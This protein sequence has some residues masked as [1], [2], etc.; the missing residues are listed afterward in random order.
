MIFEQMPYQRP[1]LQ[2]VLKVYDELIEKLKTNPPV[3]EAEKIIDRHTQTYLPV[4][5]M[6]SLSAIRHSINTEDAFYTAEEEFYAQQGPVLGEKIA[7]MY[8]LLLK[9]DCLPQLKKIF[10]EVFF[11]NAEIETKTI[12]PAVLGELEEENMLV[13]E[14]Q[15][16]Q[17]GAQIRFDGKV[18][19]LSQLGVYKEN[20]DRAVRRAAYEAE[21]GFYRQ[22]QR[23]YDEIYDKLVKVRTKIAQKLGFENF[24]ELGYLRM[25]R[26]CYRAQQVKVF[27]KEV[28]TNIVPIVAEMKKRQAARIGVTDFKL[29]DDGVIRKGG[30]PAP[31]G[32]FDDTYRAGV[33]MYRAMTPLTKEFIDKMDSMHLFDLEPKKGKMTGGY[34][35]Y[36]PAY[37]APFIFANFNGTSHDVEVFTHEGG[38]AL[39]AFMASKTVRLLECAMPTLEG[40]E[41]HSMSM[42]FLCWPWLEN[43]YGKEADAA[44]AAHLTGALY[45]LPYGCMVDE[46]QHIVY[47]NPALTPAQRNE[48]WLELEKRYR[49]WTDF[50][51]LP[52]YSEGAGWQRQIHIYTDPF[53]YIDYCLAQSVALQVFEILQEQD[54]QAA[55]E[56]YQ[57]YTRQGGSDTFLGLLEKA[58]FVNPMSQGALQKVAAAAGNYLK[59]HQND[60]EVAE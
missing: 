4:N 6:V 17:G 58:G 47:E 44:R 8:G 56:I 13:M 15:K 21:G 5:Q 28:E 36:L 12:S 31:R 46:F 34:C 35:S 3:E 43:F 2:S 14:Y 49:P 23:E 1:D 39:A 22:H 40:C 45:F 33:E 54:W 38:H 9:L 29:Y 20:A 52:F 42:E 57:R 19:N 26:N 53:Y 24:V 7:Q 55:W 25:T 37:E 51:A 48:K 60:L 18:L 30:N 32:S 10:P 11:T 16:L 59:A 50:D 41:V 27:R